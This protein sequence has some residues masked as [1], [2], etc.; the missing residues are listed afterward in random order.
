[1]TGFSRNRTYL[2][3]RRLIGRRRLI[4][5]DRIRLA[6]TERGP[7][8]TTRGEREIVPRELS[9][10][11]RKIL[12]VL[13]RPFLDAARSGC[14]SEQPGDR[15]DDAQGRVARTRAHVHR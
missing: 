1:M 7:I 9:A 6:R 5:R 13:C 11:E 12:T 8:E 15:R 2:T 4:E 10:S 3:D 14:H